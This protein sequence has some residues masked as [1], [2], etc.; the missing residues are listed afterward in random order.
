VDPVVLNLS[1]QT[2]EEQ[3]A[4]LQRVFGLE[5]RNQNLILDLKEVTLVDR[6][7]VIFLARRDGAGTRLRNCPPDISANRLCENEPEFADPD[8]HDSPRLPSGQDVW[9][10]KGAMFALYKTVSDQGRL[11]FDVAPIAPGGMRLMVFFT[12]SVGLGRGSKHRTNG[13]RKIRIIRVLSPI[14]N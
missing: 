7:A 8:P 2:D 3:V 6:D 10:V 4:E 5:V 1:R 14:G 12:P 9:S 11:E 13:S